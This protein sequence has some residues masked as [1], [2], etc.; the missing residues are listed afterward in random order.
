MKIQFV[1]PTTQRKSSVRPLGMGYLATILEQQGHQVR[2]IDNDVD[3][4]DGPEL[5]S[6]IDEFGPD[7]LG[8]TA[9]ILNRP[10]AKRIAELYG[11]DMPVVFGGPQPTLSPDEFCLK[12]NW[13]VLSGESE[14]SFPN[15][16]R[17]LETKGDFGEVRGLHFFHEGKM[18]TNM[19]EGVIKNLDDV[20]FPSMEHFQYDKYRTYI[21]GVR[22][23]N[24]MSSRGCP[25]KCIYCYHNL[26]GNYR[27]RSPENVVAEIDMLRTEYGFQGFSFYDD[28]ITVKRKYLEALCDKLENEQKGITWS[29]LS[30][31]RTVQPDTLKKMGKAGCNLIAF[32]MES[33]SQRSL[34]KM[35]K[36]ATVEDNRNVIRWCKEAG[37]KSKAYIM[38]GFPWETREDIEAT[39]RFLETSPPDEAQILVTTP[40]PGTEL[41]TLTQQMGYEIDSMDVL[42]DTRDFVQP[43]FE[44]ENFTREEIIDA[45]H[46][47]H[48]RYFAARKRRG[49]R[50][51]VREPRNIKE[52]AYELALKIKTGRIFKPAQGILTKH[53]Y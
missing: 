44:T 22:A 28:N 30:T 53:N 26:L 35:G 48:D 45:Y 14:I 11:E 3:Q 47:L 10:K 38:I 41:E 6:K 1:Q 7:V 29:C 32:G 18:V 20:P 2:I 40:M 27:H 4:L 16:L 39:A 9:N 23:T 46:E 19:P 43:T 24:I 21:D 42:E 52:R 5:K 51:L 36:G 12:K 50:H 25:F 17:T 13:F 8:I 31:V 15:F 34:D 49:K 37:V 33:G